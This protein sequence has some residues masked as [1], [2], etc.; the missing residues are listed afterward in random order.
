MSST[1]ASPARRAE[2]VL[3]SAGLGGAAGYW[4]PQLAALARA[5]SRRHLRPGRHRPQQP[6]AAG[7]S[8][9][10]RDGRRG[11]RRAGRDRAPTAAHFVGHA[12]G[13]LVGL[14]LALRQPDRLRSLTVVNGWAAAHA[15]TRR[16]FE[17]AP[18]A[19]EARAAR[20][21]TCAPSRSS[22]IPPTGWRR[23]AEPRGA[24]RGA[25]P[26]WLPGRRYAAPPHRRPARLRRHATSSRS[27]R[28][29]DADRGGA[30][31]RAG[32][33]LDV[34]AARWRAIKGATLH[35]APWGAHAINVT[36]AEILQVPSAGLSSI[37][38]CRAPPLA[39]DGT[40]TRSALYNATGTALRRRRVSMRLLAIGLFATLA[41][42]AGAASAEAPA[43]A[44]AGLYT[45]ACQRP[46]ARGCFGQDTIKDD[47]HV[48]QGKEASPVRS[49]LLPTGAREVGL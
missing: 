22:S 40:S 12:L 4:A 6:R 16:C 8:Q 30:R 28:T 35:V 48:L 39:W 23:N 37:A 25:R 26:G 19:A 21:P 29:A 47:V 36:Q 24:G 46:R 32:A 27:L 33:E 38:Q 44:T 3:L 41:A 1:R 7:R 49:R 20:Q 5:L 43:P 18:R 17:H 15:H 14:D 42:I 11:A 45:P 34:R 9:H 31:R 13:G 2:T 10:R